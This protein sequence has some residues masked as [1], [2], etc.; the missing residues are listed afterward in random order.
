MPRVMGT[1]GLAG[2]LQLCSPCLHPHRPQPG[3]N[4][5]LRL[6]LACFSPR[7]AGGFPTMKDVQSGAQKLNF[8]HS[9]VG[10]HQPCKEHC[11]GST[12][13][14]PH[15]PTPPLQKHQAR[16]HTLSRFRDTRARRRALLCKAGGAV[17]PRRAGG[18]AQQDGAGREQSQDPAGF[19]EEY[20]AHTGCLA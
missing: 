9:Q 20:P 15:T 3:I 8:H 11:P 10:R 16:P 12:P 6:L 5:T 17:R 1:S 7:P 4:P 14:P 19:P 2:A 13:G 18:S